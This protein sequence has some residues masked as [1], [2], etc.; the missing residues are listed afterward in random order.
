MRFS[1]LCRAKCKPGAVRLSTT[2]SPKSREGRLRFQLI[3][4]DDS[5]VVGR[6]QLIPLAP[7]PSL[8][9]ELDLCI[10]IPK[11]TPSSSLSSETDPA[12]VMVEGVGTVDA[13]KAIP[14]SSNN[15]ST[16]LVISSRSTAHAS[17][18]SESS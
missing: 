4:A 10:V 11:P 17:L 9:C 6:L 3:E 15:P 5:V 7:L 1:L 13:V 14:E 8:R 16:S 2:A 12:S 18:A